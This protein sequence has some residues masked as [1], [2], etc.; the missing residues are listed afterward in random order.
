MRLRRKKLC[1]G[2]YILQWTDV[3]SAA[4][5]KTSR[6]I[7]IKLSSSR[8]YEKF[9]DADTDAIEF[10]QGANE[11][12]IKSSFYCMWASKIDESYRLQSRAFKSARYAETYAMSDQVVKELRWAKK[13]NQKIIPPTFRS[14]QTKSN[15]AMGLP[16]KPSLHQLRQPNNCPFD[17]VIYFRP[18]NL[19]QLIDRLSTTKA[20]DTMRYHISHQIR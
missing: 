5:K 15:I 4:N 7:L 18:Q 3:V 17:L 20:D 10:L 16:A 14:M 13:G 1:E 8:Y 19:C 6:W 12:S 11:Q 9:A 2:I